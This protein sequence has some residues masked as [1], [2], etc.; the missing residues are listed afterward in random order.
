MSQ[1]KNMH[2]DIL[3]PVRGKV[4]PPGSDY[5]AGLEHENTLQDI[6]KIASEKPM[7][8]VPVYVHTD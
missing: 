7:T 1:E 4:K 8:F 5:V 3:S 2:F 6:S